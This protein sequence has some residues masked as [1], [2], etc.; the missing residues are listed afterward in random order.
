MVWRAEPKPWFGKH[1]Q[2]LE[3]P[4]DFSDIL[5][6][7]LSHSGLKLRKNQAPRVEGKQTGATVPFFVMSTIWCRWEI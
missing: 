2:K 3:L 7:F 5:N 6:V 4:E 1:V